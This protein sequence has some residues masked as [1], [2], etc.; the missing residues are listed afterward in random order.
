MAT[1]VSR[2]TSTG[3]LQVAGSFDEYTIANTSSSVSFN[4][5]NQYLTVPTSSFLTPSNTYTVEFWLYPVSNPAG[6][7]A[8]YQVSNSN[9]S[10][11]GDFSIQLNSTGKMVFNVR[12]STGA[13]VVTITTTASV[14]LNTWSHIAIS[15]NSGSAILFINGVNSGT[16]TVVVMD[17]TQTFCSIGYLNNG[18]TA[19]Q[20]YFAGHISNLRVVKNAALYTAN[21]T[22]PTAPLTAITNTSL[23]TCQS[24]TIIDNSI[25]NLSI[26][27]NNSALT[28]IPWST[29]IV[30]FN[31]SSQYLTAPST[32]AFAFGASV[33]FTV[34]AWVYPLAY[35][36]AP[37]G[38]SIVGTAFGAATGWSLN[39]G[40]D[41]NNFRLLSN[42]SGTW[43][44]NIVCGSNNG[45]P[46]NQW[47]HVALVRN[48]ATITLY[49]N[50]ISV[51]TP[52]AAGSAYN[53]TSPNNVV[54]I[55]LISDGSNT[56]RYM[57]G[58]ISNVRIVKGTAVYTS[59]FP[60][61]TAPLSPITNTSLLTCQNPTII[62]NSTNAFT[63][64]NSGTATVLSSQLPFTSPF[65]YPTSSIVNDGTYRV[66]GSFDEYTMPASSY[67]VSF[68]GTSQYL[69]ATSNAA[70]AF[71][72]DFTFEGWFY[73]FTAWTNTMDLVQGNGT[74]GISFY[75]AASTLRSGPNNVSSYSLGS[76]TGIPT[77]AWVH[78]AF[79]R[80]SNSARIYVNGVPLAAAVS[81]TNSY[82][83]TALYI[84]GGVDGYF[85][86][87]MSNVRVVKGTAIYDP[88]LSSFT[89]PIGPLTAIAGTSLLTCQNSTIVDNSG[90]NIAITNTG[91]A[92]TT[93]ITSTFYSGLFN[94]STQYL[95]GGGGST[96][97]YLDG[98]FTIE[99]WIYG[100]GGG[101]YRYM[102]S[103]LAAY[104]AANNVS[105][106]FRNGNGTA[107]AIFR[108]GAG[109]SAVVFAGG[110]VT[111]GVWYHIAVVRSTASSLYKVF[112]NG[113]G[114]NWTINDTGVFDYSTFTI[115]ANPSDGGVTLAQTATGGYLSNLR[116]VKGTALYRTDFTPP[117]TPLTAV[118]NT[119]LLALQ[120][121]SVTKDNSLN[122]FTITNNGAV[123]ATAPI[124][125]ASSSLTSDG[126]L[127]VIGSFDEFTG[128]PIV[129][130][131]LMVWIDP[132]QAKSYPGVGTGWGDLSPNFKDYT[133]FNTPTFSS[134]TNG[135]V[136][137]FTGA[138]SQY[139][140]HATT[141]FNSTTFN[142][143]TMNLWVYPTAAGQ[144]ISVC[145]QSTIN[146]G[147]HYSGIEITAGGLISFGQWTGAMT[148][149]ATSQQTLNQWY[150][151]VITYNGTTATAYVNG[152]SVGSS[153]IAWSSPG[154][155]TF[156]ALMATDSTN[157]GTTGYASG[158]IGSFMAYNRGLTADEV[159]QNYNATRKRYA[160]PYTYSVSFNGSNQYLS[161]S[162][163]NA[164]AFGT[165]D[166]TVECWLY[167]TNT[168][169]SKIIIS[170]TATNSFYLRYGTSYG[171]NNGLGIGKAGA[172]DNENC[173]FT[174]LTN[175][176][177]H[178]A[179]VRQTNV[180]K[181][182][183]N[184]GLQ[185]TSGTGTASLSY[186]N[187]TT[188]YVGWGGTPSNE[189]FSGN[190]SNLRVVKGTAVYTA[191][192]TPLT[193]PLSAITNTSLL[194]C[195]SPT[196]I[197]TSTNKF[198]ITNNGTAVVSASVTPF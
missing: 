185:T 91:T 113:V 195:Q 31:G 109:A 86:G 130:S 14:T 104:T 4:G 93:N 143:Y 101:L 32:T 135:G 24:P 48:G 39:L 140:Q 58:Y 94:G 40:Q 150:N 34:E 106:A 9:T 172:S 167:L 11:F 138:S 28:A 15:V 16:S 70:F 71:P 57:N 125:F 54:Y 132:T 81:D 99:F 164:L 37:Y 190:I 27:N 181:F 192:F 68:N 179:V 59:N 110:T 90:N 129:D 8:I 165:G 63:I 170:G 111:D 78:I 118:A 116:V 67:S 69:I 136:I 50:G 53:F 141:L 128:N 154:A 182:F 56:A 82:S 45:P 126:T 5:I 87:Y 103:K 10:A 100:N 114:Y 112:I 162:T 152:T 92:T 175:T 6:I 60:R 21:F 146:T 183:I 26:T 55:G 155:S 169:G 137:T 76:S 98:D 191:N 62:D 97:L 3:N 2:L 156:F 131:S 159:V 29:N 198:T 22:K 151:L 149:I 184:G 72:G 158:S 64:T 46:L 124:T 88:T 36:A 121:S 35:G 188:T 25:N 194:T 107:F 180:V 95:T 119:S 41:I 89:P 52:I 186:G 66:F 123:T 108:G 171:V 161:S 163:T 168:T 197:D 177:Y 19:G 65:V 30:S 77:N 102:F 12:P 193:S 189:F 74:G 115:M 51:G 122:N 133:L 23:L 142:T 196:I 117:T 49:K 147:Y 13:A 96:S 17:G 7:A 80:K 75:S 20:S 85:D 47:T 173:S 134:S 84:G 105:L 79:V 148:T 73:K 44:D 166:Y 174:F 18:Y 153:A 120:T 38:T 145:G 61:P 178:V 176:W 33:N 83:Q 144:I 127:K 139:A 43:A 157:M 42:A 187:E 1:T 160:L